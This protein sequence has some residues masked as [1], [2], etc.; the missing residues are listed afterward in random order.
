MAAID[1][2]GGGRRLHLDGSDGD[3]LN[4]LVV[5][6]KELWP[7]LGPPA[8]PE[9]DRTGGAVGF[10]TENTFQNVDVDRDVPIP[11]SPQTP[12]T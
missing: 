4:V 5:F 12:A 8:E 3:P 1:M 9:P 6:A 7:L 2:S 10:T 11:G